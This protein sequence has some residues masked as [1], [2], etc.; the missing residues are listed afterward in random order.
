MFPCRSAPIVV[1]CIVLSL[2]IGSS[3]SAVTVMDQIGPLDGS[4]LAGSAHASQDFEPANDTYDIAAID[5]FF[6]SG[7]MRI[8]Q[9]A[10]AMQS[11]NPSGA[12][13]SG[14]QHW[15]VEVYSA[16][17]AAAASLTGDVAS[18]TVLPGDVAL[19]EPFVATH[20]LL[21]EIPVSLVLPGGGLY[22]VAVIPRLDFAGYGQVGA[23]DAI[24]GLPGGANAMQANPNG[25]F[26]FVD[27]L[28]SIGV[29][30][31][32]RVEATPLGAPIPEPLTVAGLVMGIGG[33]GAYLRRRTG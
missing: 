32:Y 30:L 26:G 23:Y 15:R 27:D 4:N 19:T 20:D 24:S 5:D 18:A 11:W 28:D 7:A 12:Y 9:V 31:A 33:I 22:W 17:S 10:A 21:V 2:G 16:S 14:V 8:T 3:A 25:G 13:G 6:V 1:V 29:N